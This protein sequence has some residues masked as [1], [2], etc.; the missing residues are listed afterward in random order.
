M[1]KERTKERSKEEKE[2]EECKEQG[3]FA[4]IKKERT[5]RFIS[6]SSLKERRDRFW[7][8]IK[9]YVNAR[10]REYPVEAVH[11]FFLYW[12]QMVEIEDGFGGVTTIFAFEAEPRWGLPHRLSSYIKRGAWL[13]ERRET[14]FN[15]AKG[16][17]PKNAK[18]RDIE[19]RQRL[20]REIDRQEAAERERERD[21]RARRA[22]PP[23]D[24]NFEDLVRSWK[25][26]EGNGNIEN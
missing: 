4:L 13:E 10:H 6:N 21:E 23:P 15:S 14:R 11:N 26:E 2:E 24:H 7:E 19:E 9:T 12:T 16:I 25:Q 8:E 3:R 20:A 1:T 18:Q 17:K 22:A 5:V